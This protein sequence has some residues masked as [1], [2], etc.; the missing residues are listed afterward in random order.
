MAQ[1]D[2]FLNWQTPH[3][4][5]IYVNHLILFENLRLWQ[6]CLIPKI[7]RITLNCEIPIAE[8]LLVH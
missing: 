3:Y 5:L 2:G 8:D 7:D 6:D 4:V 1:I